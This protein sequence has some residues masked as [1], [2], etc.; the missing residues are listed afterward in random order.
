[1]NWNVTRLLVYVAS[2]AA[3]AL[4]LAGLADFDAAT[5]NFDLAPFN[6]YAAVGAIGGIVSSALAALALWRGWGRK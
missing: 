2:F 6:L 5:G 3:S 1:M 4:A